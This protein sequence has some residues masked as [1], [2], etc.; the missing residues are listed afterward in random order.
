VGLRKYSRQ[1]SDI[2]TCIEIRGK[3]LR[4]LR[5]STGRRII[6]KSRCQVLLLET[7]PRDGTTGWP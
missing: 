5:R 2:V 4:G 3:F 7:F 6:E 1:V